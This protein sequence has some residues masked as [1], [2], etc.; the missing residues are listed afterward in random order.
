M[1]GFICGCYSERGVLRDKRGVTEREV[2]YRKREVLQGKRGGRES[3]YERWV[4]AWGGWVVLRANGARDRAVVA[5]LS[6]VC[7]LTIVSIA[8]SPVSRFRDA[9]SDAVATPGILLISLE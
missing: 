2:C 6:V 8:R 7:T 4:S 5:T 1:H 9:V 3:R